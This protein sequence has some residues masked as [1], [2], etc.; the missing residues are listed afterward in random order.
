MSAVLVLRSVRD[1]IEDN[2]LRRGLLYPWWVPVTSFLGELGCVL[3]ALA[4]RGE[5]WPPQLLALTIVM[6][7]VSPVVQFGFRVWLPWP[8]DELGAVLAA[9]WLMLQPMAD[10]TAMDAA[11]ALLV[12][13]TAA[14][15]ARDG[16][17]VGATVG[18]VCTAAIGVIALTVGPP[19]L[20]LWMLEVPFG[21]VIGAML[22]WMM[23]ALVAERSAREQA[24]QQATTAERERIAREIHD[25]VAHSLSVTLL[26]VTGARHALRDVEDGTATATDA[27][28]EVD[29]ALA[30][31]EQVGRRAMSDIR[32]TVSTMTQGDSAPRQPLP[33]AADIA[34]LVRQTAAAGLDV[35]YEEHGDT[36][37]VPAAAGL[38]LYRIAQ[39][40]LANVAKHAPTAR[41]RVRLSVGRNGAHLTVRN[42]LTGQPVRDPI[43]S[44][45]AGMAARAEGLGATLTAGPDGREWVVDVRMGTGAQP[46]ALPTCGM[47]AT[48]RAAAGAAPA[49]DSPD[50]LQPEPPVPTEVPQ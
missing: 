25:L 27:V 5:L 15:V 21:F 10:S 6:V 33:G 46:S 13:A 42:R 19:S 37:R 47:V 28:A 12:I 39:E 8:V 50:V 45:L 18:S 38:G 22:R 4:L 24:W 9:T 2:C 48:F 43:G 30:D 44:G 23:R 17:R 35:A 16:V 41:T 34:A 32:R 7:L 1:R 49:Y 40:S 20:A 26:H 36:T 14:A 3:V 11:P 29:A 31:A